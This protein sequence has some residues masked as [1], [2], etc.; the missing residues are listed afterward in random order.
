MATSRHSGCRTWI[1]S[2][3]CW[4][5]SEHL[6]RETGCYNWH[7][8]E[9]WSHGASHMTGWTMHAI[10][11]VITPRCFSYT[12]HTQMC[13]L[14]SCKGGFKSSLAPITPSEESMSIKRSKKRWTRTHRRQGTK[15]F[16]LKPGAVSRYYLT[17]EYKA[18][19]PKTPRDMTGQTSSSQY[20]GSKDKERWSRHQ[21]P[22]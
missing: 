8:Y 2:K 10:S 13:T 7:L 11:H 19:Y 16:S 12:R 5:S 1:W 15:R 21:V 17:A 4:A 9:P 18:V 20:V 14:K 22:D 3:V 6:E